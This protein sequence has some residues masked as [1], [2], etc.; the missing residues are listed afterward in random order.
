MSIE[1]H[2]HILNE[3]DARRILRHLAEVSEAIWEV[4]AERKLKLTMDSEAGDTDLSPPHTYD[5]PEI[6]RLF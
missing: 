2:V 4:L 1:G 6:N 3:D 5:P